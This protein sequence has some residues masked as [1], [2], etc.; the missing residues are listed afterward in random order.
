VCPI[1]KALREKWLRTIKNN[2]GANNREFKKWEEEPAKYY[3]AK[4]VCPIIKGL[5]F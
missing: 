5:V 1:A 2:K 4:E 3:I